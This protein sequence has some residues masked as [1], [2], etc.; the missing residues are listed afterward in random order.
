MKRLFLTAVFGTAAMLAAS[1]ASATSINIDFDALPT[2]AIGAGAFP[3]LVFTNTT[4]VVGG[5]FEASSPNAI[6]STSS[7][8]LWGQ[9]DAVGVTFNTPATSASIVGLNVGF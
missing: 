8:F 3:D 7:P 1:A 4:V 6:V 5:G 9:A 2:G